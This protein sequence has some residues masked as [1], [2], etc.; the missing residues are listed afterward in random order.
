MPALDDTWGLFL[1]NPITGMDHCL[2]HG[3]KDEDPSTTVQRA[4]QKVYLAQQSV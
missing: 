3:I 1:W 2:A 4:R